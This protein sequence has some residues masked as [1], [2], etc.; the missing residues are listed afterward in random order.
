MS[1]YAYL[2]QPYRRE[3]DSVITAVLPEGLVLGDTVFHPEGGGQPGDR[4][5]IN[6]Q[7]VSDTRMIEGSPVHIMEDV[8]A[9]SVGDAVSMSIDWQWR[10]RFMKAHTAEHM[11]AGTLYSLA[12]IGVLAIHLG[13][14]A[15]TIETDQASIPLETLHRVEDAVNKAIHEDHAV[16]AYELS[17]DDAMA[18]GLRRPPK[19]DGLTRIVEVEGVDRIACGGVHVASTAEVG[20]VGFLSSEKIRGHVR[21]IWLYS[22]A[23]S[24]RRHEE[25]QLASDIGALLSVPFEGVH[26]AV[27]RLV[28]ESK[29]QKAALRAKDEVIAQLALSLHGPVFESAVPVDAYVKLAGRRF[30]T[31]HVEEGRLRWLLSGSE[32][33]FK[34]LKDLYGHFGMKGGGRAPLWQGSASCDA[35]AL[36]GA[37]RA[38]LEDVE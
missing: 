32:D 2:A 28:E 31:V 37:V 5:W 11:I 6:G 22:D 35:D 15:L 24:G 17:H 20:E 14:D 33:D 7:P 36:L 4:G 10:H 1:T 19:V 38:L 18:L 34:H 13:E 3:L 25:R 16:R 29:G 12:G 21:T 8:S 30:F 26:G 23:A 27:E 9:F